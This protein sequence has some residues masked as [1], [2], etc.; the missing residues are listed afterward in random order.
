MRVQLSFFLCLIFFAITFVAPA[1][2]DCLDTAPK[3]IDAVSG[4]F[5][6]ILNSLCKKRCNLTLEHWHIFENS[7][8]KETDQVFTEDA[9]ER[10]SRVFEGV[11]HN[12]AQDPVTKS[13]SFCKEETQK[14]AFEIIENTLQS[15]MLELLPLLSECPKT[16]KYLNDPKTFPRWRNGA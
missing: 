2:A 13:G 10:I 16:L 8:R 14:R 5:K 15:K 9:S 12:L 1:H 7:L 4:E 3:Q 6:K 11:K